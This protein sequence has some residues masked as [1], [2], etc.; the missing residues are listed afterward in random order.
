VA[1]RC[2]SAH[3]TAGS[4][5]GAPASHTRTPTAR[6]RHRLRSGP[7]TSGRCRYAPAPLR[8][9]TA[10]ARGAPA[11]GECA[12]RS[13]FTASARGGAECAAR[14]MSA[15][16]CSRARTQRIGQTDGRADRKTPER[17]G[18]ESPQAWLRVLDADRVL[19][20]L[21]PRGAGRITAVWYDLASAASQ[22]TSA[23]AVRSAR[24]RATS[25]CRLSSN[26][27]CGAAPAAQSCVRT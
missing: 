1:E 5:Y 22:R 7:A 27:K 16:A 8:P 18:G 4:T 11:Y 3:A 21:Y 12:G 23:A 19:G 9:L 25:G 17:T 10:S 20:V 13:R 15:C 26:L 24:P 14:A 2:R 6:P